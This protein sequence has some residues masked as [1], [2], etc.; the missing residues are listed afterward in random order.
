MCVSF[1]SQMEINAVN[2]PDCHP[3][4]RSHLLSGVFRYRFRIR[5]PTDSSR[6]LPYRLIRPFRRDNPARLQS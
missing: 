1:A 4:D 5:V 3:L 2:L 6:Y